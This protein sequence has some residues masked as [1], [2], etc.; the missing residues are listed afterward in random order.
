MDDSIGTQNRSLVATHKNRFPPNMFGNTTVDLLEKSNDLGFEDAEV[1]KNLNVKRYM[2]NL[3]VLEKDGLK[4]AIMPTQTEEMVLTALYQNIEAFRF[5]TNQT[6][7]VCEMALGIKP[8][9]IKLFKEQTKEHVDFALKHNP[10]LIQHIK[11]PT[12]EQLEFVLDASYGYINFFKKEWRTEYFIKY[13]I[14]LCVQDMRE[15]TESNYGSLSTL[16]AAN[17]LNSCSDQQTQEIV[18]YALSKNIKFIISAKSEF[19]T[20]EIVETAIIKVP[21]IIKYVHPKFIT[22]KLLLGAIDRISGLV[23]PKEYNK[24]SHNE[25]VNLH[26]FVS[27]IQPN[28]FT[29]EIAIK[30]IKIGAKYYDNYH[31]LG[32]FNWVVWNQNSGHVRTVSFRNPTLK[33]VKAITETELWFNSCQF[34]LDDTPAGDAMVI[35]LLRYDYKLYEQFN[36]SQKSMKRKIWKIKAKHNLL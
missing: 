16:N 32:D 28:D 36:H 31:N 17:P 21:A 19:L 5:V 9:L 13:A 20:D 4:L 24:F 27:R 30:I 2:R 7:G 26:T 6:P 12:E 34:D 18:D 35:H 29:E 14:D 33:M 11:E 1:L 23:S 22:L 8:E 25:G 15:N 3:E 10:K